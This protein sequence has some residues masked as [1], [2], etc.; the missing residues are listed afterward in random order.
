MTMTNIDELWPGGPKYMQ[1]PGVFKLGS[2]SVLLAA[3]AKLARVRTVC[4]LGSGGGVLPIV[5]QAYKPGCE[6]TGLEIE[7]DTINIVICIFICLCE[8]FF[9]SARCKSLRNR[10]A[11]KSICKKQNNTNESYRNNNCRNFYNFPLFELKI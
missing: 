5:L 6:I 10:I 3:F 11:E 4:D 9:C 1:R 2:D 8:M 7:S